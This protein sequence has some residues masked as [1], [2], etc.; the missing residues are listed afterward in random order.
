M[1]LLDPPK[2]VK[3]S[4][5]K[6][7]KAHTGGYDP[8]EE[9]SKKPSSKKPARAVV[10]YRDPNET[11]SQQNHSLS[12]EGGREGKDG[13]EGGYDP[14]LGYHRDYLKRKF[15][16]YEI[17][18]NFLSPYDGRLCPLIIQSSEDVLQSQPKSTWHR[19][20]IRHG[21]PWMIR[22]ANWAM[23]R[24][25]GSEDS[26]GTDVAVARRRW[27][28]ACLALS[29]LI[30]LPIEVAATPSNFG[31]YD[32]FLYKDWRYPLDAQNKSENRDDTQINN[33]HSEVQ[34]RRPV[35]GQRL[36]LAGPDYLCFIESDGNVVPSKVSDW[37]E[38][39]ERMTSTDYVFVSFFGRHFP[40]SKGNKYLQDVGV[41]AARAIGVNAYWSS[42]SC[43]W[44]LD[45]EDEGK[46][47]REKEQTIWNMSDIIRRASAI[48]IAV[49]GPLDAQF[50]GDSLK[51]W[52]NRSWTMPELLLYTGHHPIFIY[53]QVKRLDERRRLPRREL[54]NK[55][56]SDTAYSG[57]L[58][59]HYE[60]SLMLTPL[61]LNTV[62]LHCLQNRYTTTEYLPG[63]V[64]YIL[65]GLLQQRPEVVASD[66]EFQAFARL[67]LANDSNLLLER[68]ICLLPSSLDADWWSLEDAWNAT[69]WDI[70]PKSQ[71]CGIGE[72]ETV[73]LDGAHGAAIRWDRFVPVL[74]LGDETL[75]HR[76]AR[77]TFRTMPAFF[78]I[79]I[80]WVIA[81]VVTSQW[82]SL[83]IGGT[84]LSLSAVIVFLSPLLLRLIYSTK[85]RDSQP[86]FFGIE[87]YLDK[88]Q[89][90]LLIFG[91]YE[92]RLNWSA[93]NSPLSRHRLD[94]EGMRRDFPNLD[95]ESLIEQN[96]YTGLDPVEADDGVKDLVEK[97]SRSSLHEKKIFTLVDTYTMTITLFEAVRPPVAVVVC[98]AE[99]G[100][101][102]A[103]LCS[104]EWTTGTLFRETVLR[105]ETRVW[106]KM[107][108]LPRVRLGLKRKDTRDAID[109]SQHNSLSSRQLGIA[110]W[111]I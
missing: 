71:I 111:S 29:L 53:E 8:S 13:H 39:N 40:G 87:G 32:P 95:E 35:V 57:Q 72:G 96:M 4:A 78:F 11:R 18:E 69:L 64:A 98:A 73:I 26:V 37:T 56:W 66:S 54:W 61:E 31:R 92:G 58:I 106:D 59:D 23:S 52:G 67:S 21:S 79:G 55:T 16:G 49:P 24:D 7:H 99:G 19:K 20:G 51:E 63:E 36:K 44:N 2:P 14:S 110:G 68:M 97:A 89:L 76:L 83:A 101:Q 10:D 100:M 9:A 108:T 34:T 90:E 15:T 27:L 12:T 46:N 105:M 77:W 88:Y 17:N 6:V 91:S 60:G 74:T 3:T 85:T 75:R 38:E 80:I 103:L 102:R 109:D 42:N 45:E 1:P 47:K 84:L 28:P 62:A 70:Y 30:S 41:D 5:D 33:R 22:I 65:M 107:D 43:L 25:H 93:A 82:A 104:E 48:A 94:R 81:S 86:F 50:N